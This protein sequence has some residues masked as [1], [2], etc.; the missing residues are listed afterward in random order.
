M[1]VTPAWLLGVVAV[2]SVC[3]VLFFG[4][5]QAVRDHEQQRQKEAFAGTPEE[6]YFD[7]LAAAA[8]YICEAQMEVQKGFMDGMTGTQEDKSKKALHKMMRDAGSVR[9]AFNPD[10]LIPAG[11]P[12]K[13]FPC[14]VSGNV[15]QTPPDIADRFRN[16][17]TYLGQE[18]PYA[19]TQV[20]KA[21]NCEGKDEKDDKEGPKEDTTENKMTYSET[22]PDFQNA[23][24]EEKKTY[25]DARMTPLAQALQDQKLL[26]LCKT[27]KVQGTEL[28]EKKRK[29]Q[30]GELKP[31]C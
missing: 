21:I 14:P 29:F 24:D 28:L 26:S 22:F 18:I 27:V 8:D 10:K 17:V 11:P 3:L 4:L 2:A 13:L 6:Q 25:L 20:N 16:S 5:L 30:S 7:L 15:F 23:S 19:L 9:T 1:K 12:K 31:N